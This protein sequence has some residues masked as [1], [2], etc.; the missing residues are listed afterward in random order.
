MRQFKMT[1]FSPSPSLFQDCISWLVR[2][3]HCG[4]LDG[5]QDFAEDQ[6]VNNVKED[7]GRGEDDSRHPVDANRS[8]APLLHDLFRI[9]F[10]GQTKT[11]RRRCSH[12]ELDFTVVKFKVE[13]FWMSSAR[14]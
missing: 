10:L 6:P 11:R 7:E 2:R 13:I 3:A 14:I 8:L 9:D 4:P 1:L 5:V 12:L